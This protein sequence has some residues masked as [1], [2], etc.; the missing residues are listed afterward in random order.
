MAYWSAL[1]IV[2]QAAAEL[3][4]PRPTSLFGTDDVQT[5]QLLAYL[6]SSGNELL[7]YY[8]WEQFL[9]TWTFSTVEGQDRYDLPLDW[10]YFLD[11]TQWDRTDHWPLLGPKS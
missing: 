7:L 5:N 1:S 8:P 9:E 11:Q 6:N 3:G 2:S 10:K 4:L